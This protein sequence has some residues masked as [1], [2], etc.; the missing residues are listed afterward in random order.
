MA[1]ADQGRG[2]AWEGFG[3]V[4]GGEGVGLVGEDHQVGAL[5]AQFF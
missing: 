5:G 3:A 1:A 2:Q 4:G